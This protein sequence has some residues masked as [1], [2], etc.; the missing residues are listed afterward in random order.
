MC[1]LC[2]EI[3]KKTMTS[4]EIARGLLEFPLEDEHIAEITATIA[5]NY[6][7][8]EVE[9]EMYKLAQERTEDL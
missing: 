2:V 6:N 8:D 5:D 4:A 9:H 7:V 3:N 1:I